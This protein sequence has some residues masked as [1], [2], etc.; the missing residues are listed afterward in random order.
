MGVTTGARF[1]FVTLQLKLVLAVVVPSDTNTVT[2]CVPA[3]AYDS[4]PDTAPVAPLMTAYGGRPVA[5]KVNGS[6]SG[7]V[8]VTLKEIAA[9]S[10]FVLSEIEVTIGGRFT[11]VTAHVNA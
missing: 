4:V 8:A 7:S 1:T 9:F 3:L 11:F 2:G 10:T 6:P 5:L